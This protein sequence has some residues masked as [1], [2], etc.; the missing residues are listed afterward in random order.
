MTTL[1][2]IQ[3]QLKV[4]KGQHNSFGGYK[5]RSC[6]DI[7]EAVKKQLPEDHH[8]IITDEIVDISG[9]VYVKATARLVN[10]DR[11]YEAVG[12]AREP[13]SKK[14]MDE[15]QIT[16]ATSSYARKYALNGLF[17]IDDAKDADSNEHAEEVKNTPDREMTDKE[18]YVFKDISWL[19]HGTE[20]D[21]EIDT[22]L[23]EYGAVIGAF[24]E[25]NQAEIMQIADDQRQKRAAGVLAKTNVYHFSGVNHALEYMKGMK[26]KI[27]QATDAK[28]LEAYIRRWDGKLQALDKTLS[29]KTYQ[30]DE[31]SPY[32]QVMNI[33]N[34]KMTELLKEKK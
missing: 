10:C 5:Y 19:I 34:A 3:K 20:H 27:P 22:I 14:G 18:K 1:H 17:C 13:L 32:Q 28:K 11:V 29:A 9:R 4:P 24:P 2:E 12:W 15:S 31:G 30:N 25:N 6:E 23:D 16:G 7:L 26:E 8:L 21:V 33:Y